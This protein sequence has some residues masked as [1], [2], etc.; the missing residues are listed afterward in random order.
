MRVVPKQPTLNTLEKHGSSW[1]SSLWTVKL[2]PSTLSVDA[3]SP[4]I[5]PHGSIVTNFLALLLEVH[6]SAFFKSGE[7]FVEG[8]GVGV[9]VLHPLGDLSGGG[10]GGALEIDPHLLLSVRGYLIG[11]RRVERRGACLPRHRQEGDQ[12]FLREPGAAPVGRKG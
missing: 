4:S 12:A 6:G 9:D 1:S 5:V 8:S 2:Q 10:I 11:E 7:D 3:G